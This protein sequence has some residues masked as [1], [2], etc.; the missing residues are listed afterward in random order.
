MPWA[1]AI[2]PGRIDMTEDNII[3]YND[4]SELVTSGRE[5]DDYDWGWQ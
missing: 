4:M 2:T 1:S 3:D 5:D